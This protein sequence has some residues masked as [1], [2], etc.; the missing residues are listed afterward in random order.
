[1]NSPLQI[2]PPA[3]RLERTRLKYG[4]IVLFTLVGG[5]LVAAPIF[6][7]N[8]VFAQGAQPVRPPEAKAPAQTAAGA[9]QKQAIRVHISDRSTYDDALKCFQFYAIAHETASKVATLDK[10]TAEQ[11]AVVQNEAG[12][13][14]FLQ[15]QW[16][17]RITKTKGDRTEAA[18][19]A[20]LKKISG[21]MLED[22]NKALGGDKPARDRG[23]AQGKACTAFHEVTKASP[24]AG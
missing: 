20:D 23:T 18:V 8:P 21:S 2:R 3:K 13:A 12:L 19:N 22:A 10:L 7:A 24:P 6:L 14:K 11:K 16:Q 17:G 9:A 4:K 1:M 15:V 5:A